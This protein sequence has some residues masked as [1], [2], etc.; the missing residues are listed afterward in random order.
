MELKTFL[1]NSFI[2]YSVCVYLL[3]LDLIF[4]IGFMYESVH[5]T[6]LKN[7]PGSRNRLIHFTVIS[8][9]KI[10]SFVF[11]L[12]GSQKAF[13]KELSLKTEVPL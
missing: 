6:L 12:F 9:G 1:F 2:L 3:L 4:F 7:H 13:W 5:K 10:D 8:V 11:K